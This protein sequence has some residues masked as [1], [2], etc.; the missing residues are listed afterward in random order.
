MKGNEY[1]RAAALVRHVDQLRAIFPKARF[2]D[3]GVLWAM[4]VELEGGVSNYSALLCNGA[5]DPTE[6]EMDGEDRR[7][8]DYLNQLLDNYGNDAVPLLLNNDPRGHALKIDD[9]WVRAHPEKP[10]AR[11]M[12]GYGIL[13]P[14]FD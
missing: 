7:N 13:V 8:L 2:R 12:G 9:D 14:D 10:I 6:D 4:L 5:I 3:D 1:T 11:D